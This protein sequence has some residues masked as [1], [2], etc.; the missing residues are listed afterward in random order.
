[1][2]KMSIFGVMSFFILAF[3]VSCQG[4]NG[5]GTNL[6]KPDNPEK[7]SKLL[8]KFAS[9][10]TCVDK[11]NKPVS[12]GKEVKIGEKYTFTATLAQDEKVDAWYVN[13]AKKTD[14][15]DKIFVYTVVATDG[16]QNGNDKVITVEFKKTTGGNGKLLL[17]FNKDACDCIAAD[18][19]Y[20]NTGVVEVQPGEKY[21]F[22]AK[23]SEGKKVKVWCVNDTEKADQTSEEFEYTVDATDGR[24]DGKDK[25]ITISFKLDDLRKVKIKFG[26]KITCGQEG[27]SIPTDT[28]IFE[29]TPLVFTAK[30]DDGKIVAEWLKNNKKIENETGGTLIYI[31]KYEDGED[32]AGSKAITISFKD[33]AVE[34]VTIKFDNKKI[35]ALD[36]QDNSIATGTE[37]LE[38]TNI[39]FT[40]TDED[41]EAVFWYINANKHTT[42]KEA[43]L[44]YIVKSSD[45]KDEGGKKVIEVDYKDN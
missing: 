23:L 7:P 4:G 32:D 31:V 19:T 30:L 26:D 36:D 10:V 21:T 20:K 8:L 34:K 1:M 24:E 22:Q 27:K 2:K 42:E 18:N 45:A 25:V 33:K 12:T 16:K 17:K 3:F 14:Q 40:P 28:D 41:I 35:E 13:D 9:D 38:G 39:T 6:P 5:G 44:D 29:G 15:K 11:D 43:Q 37:V